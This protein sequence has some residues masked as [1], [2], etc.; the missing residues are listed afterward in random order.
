MAPTR[1]VLPPADKATD[2]PKSSS[3]DVPEAV[4][5]AVWDQVPPRRVAVENEAAPAMPHGVRQAQRARGLQA[6]ED[7]RPL[8]QRGF[9]LRVRP[10]EDVHARGEFAFDGLETAEMAQREPGEHR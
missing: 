1:A 6:R 2:D 5:S 10:H 4:S 7:A 3:A 9:P 8:Q